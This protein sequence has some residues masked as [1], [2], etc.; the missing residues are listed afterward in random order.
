MAQRVIRH[1]GTFDVGGAQV[2]V[3]DVA[4]AAAAQAVTA[5]EVAVGDDQRLAELVGRDFSSRGQVGAD[6]PGRRR[7]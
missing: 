1:V 3:D 4:H 5:R 7:A 6:A 2:A